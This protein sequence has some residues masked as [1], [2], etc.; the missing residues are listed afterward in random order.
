MNLWKRFNP[1]QKK[2]KQKTK[3]NKKQQKNNIKMNPRK[4]FSRAMISLAGI[5][6]A[7]GLAG[8][9]DPT[10]Q[11]PIPKSTDYFAVV[12]MSRS[13]GMALTSGDFNNDG[14][15]DFV[16]GSSDNWQEGILYFYQGDGK[17]NF[18]LKPKQMDKKY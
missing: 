17:G 16:V 5:A 7:S 10:T 2:F 15:L 18:T 1:K 6:L 9:E 13:S 14:N 3:I 11:S 8:C 12:P 4:T